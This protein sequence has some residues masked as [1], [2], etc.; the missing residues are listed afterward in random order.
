MVVELNFLS[1]KVII[2]NPNPINYYI[3]TIFTLFDSADKKENN[4]FFNKKKISHTIKKYRI[5]NT[6]SLLSVFKE[7]SLEVTEDFTIGGY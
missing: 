4:D 2:N 7:N 3:K 5:Q 6:N 1:K